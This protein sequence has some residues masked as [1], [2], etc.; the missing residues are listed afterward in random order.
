MIQNIFIGLLCV[1]A[2]AAAIWGNRGSFEKDDKKDTEKCEE[3]SD[4]KN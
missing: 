1:I 2:L 4:K 3:S